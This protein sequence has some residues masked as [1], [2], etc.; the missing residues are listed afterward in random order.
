MTSRYALGK[1]V[2]QGCPISPVLFAMFINDIFKKLTAKGMKVPHSCGIHEVPGLLF[3]D[4]S[5]LLADN[6]SMM[7]DALRV[8]G[9]WAEIW[10]MGFNV[11]K[12][13]LLAVP[14]MH[15]EE[16][17]AAARRELEAEGLQLSG[18]TV[19]VAN[20]C[21][22][23][24]M[25]ITNDLSM[26]AMVDTRVGKGRA[27]LEELKPFLLE[28][29]MPLKFKLDIIRSNLITTLTYGCE[30]WG[31]SLNRCAR[32]NSIAM[33]AIRMAVTGIPTPRRGPGFSVITMAAD[34]GIPSVYEISVM[35]SARLY[36]KYMYMM[37]DT[38]WLTS[39]ISTKA[40]GGVGAQGPIRKLIAKLRKR[41]DM[42]ALDTWGRTGM[43]RGEEVKLDKFNLSKEIRPLARAYFE[44][45]EAA[46]T[47]S[48]DMYR[49]AGLDRTSAAVLVTAVAG[50]PAMHSMAAFMLRIRASPNHTCVHKVDG[51]WRCH[52]CEQQVEP[53]QGWDHIL[54][55]CSELNMVRLSS[56]IKYNAPSKDVLNGLN[57]VMRPE[58][59][60][61]GNDL[62]GGEIDP[63]EGGS[64]LW[65]DNEIFAW[66]EGLQQGLKRMITVYRGK[67]RVTFP[68]KLSPSPFCEPRV[69]RT[70]D[71]LP[72]PTPNQ[73]T[74]S[75][76][77]APATLDYS[78]VEV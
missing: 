51:V 18:L 59:T 12:C 48:F 5:A 34:L 62:P 17:L 78:S 16:R 7:R 68:S 53:E 58:T 46:K 25:P 28:K 71:S 6:P 77:V 41:V 30:I 26:D 21:V 50:R 72:E 13:Q 44:E 4:D 37:K 9:K 43:L 40:K 67:R 61:E 70:G 14:P 39:L 24:G 65:A 76:C 20:R 45:K 75:L 15:T 73:G 69:P 10:G 2:R 56:G 19:P 49:A 64:A 22:Y 23:L 36:M 31:G 55:E 57:S 52:L 11:S 63:L 60:Y 1:G 29:F 74:A 27:R 47:K 35:L 33:Q 54:K 32:V 8:V 66:G 38:S 42:P 3:A